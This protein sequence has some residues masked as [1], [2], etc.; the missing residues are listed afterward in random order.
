MSITGIYP[1]FCEHIT[2]LDAKKE[3]GQESI[4]MSIPEIGWLCS[5]VVWLACAGIETSRSTILG[6]KS[7]RTEFQIDGACVE[8]IK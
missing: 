8:Q 4:K 1:E 6:R 2:T 5:G 3:G 7:C